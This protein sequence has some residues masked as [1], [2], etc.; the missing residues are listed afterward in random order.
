M[1]EIRAEF[2]SIGNT[3]GPPR[4]Y[5]VYV[6]KL[7]KGVLRSRKFKKANRRYRKGKPCVYVGST[8]LTPEERFQVHM[9]DPERGSKWVKRHGKA[10]FPWAYQELPTFN[11]REE[12]ERVEAEHADQLRDRGWGVWQK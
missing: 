3:S 1:G 7:R 9:S 5:C 10:L 6:I 8:F 2:R 4:T 12:A 11:S